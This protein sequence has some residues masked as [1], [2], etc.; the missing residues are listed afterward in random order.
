[1]E[2]NNCIVHGLWIGPTLSP[3]EMMCIRS[4]LHAGHTFWLWTYEPTALVPEGTI[5]KNAADILP[6]NAIFRY[7]HSNKF[8]HGKGS[9][10][11]FS[12]IFR[13]K[14]L[15]E[16][17]GWWTDMDI[18]CLRPLDIP[19]PYVFRNNGEKGIVGNLMKCPPGSALMDYCYRRASAEMDADNKDWLL[20]IRILNEGLTEFKLDTFRRTMTNEDSW[21]FVS[22]LLIHP[23]TLPDNWYAIHWM[24]EEWRRLHI[25]KQAASPD[26]LFGELLERHGVP[27]RILNH[28]EVQQLQRNI[29]LWNY[30]WVNIKARLRWMLGM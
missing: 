5:V 29:G 11:G 12:D 20:P 6:E 28:S 15:H 25:D 10:A 27:H 13:Y 16:Y 30:R 7:K 18:T 8:G 17:G 1:M 19:E 9:L 26:S 2:K 21:T 3:I 4:Y 22:E 24:N 14:L 23:Y